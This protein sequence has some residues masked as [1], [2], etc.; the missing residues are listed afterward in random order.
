MPSE[1]LW[2][3][4]TLDGTVEDLRRI[5]AELNFHEQTTAAT[6]PG[7]ATFKIAELGSARAQ[8]VGPGRCQLFLTGPRAPDLNRVCVV[9]YAELVRR[10]M[11]APPPPLEPLSA[12]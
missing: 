6:G 2:I 12:A 8:D 9:L 7:W 1:D 5:V 11:L 3:D 10:G 4:W